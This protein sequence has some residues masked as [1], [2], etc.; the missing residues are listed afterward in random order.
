MKRS[1]NL[2]AATAALGLLSGA[3]VAQAD[4]VSQWDMSL[5]TPAQSQ[6]IIAYISGIPYDGFGIF[7]FV[8]PGSLVDPNTGNVAADGFMP[9]GWVL[10]S[11]GQQISSPITP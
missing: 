4:V 5:T 2:M 6:Q 10:F 8:E 3:G 9:S 7:N 1:R 11:G